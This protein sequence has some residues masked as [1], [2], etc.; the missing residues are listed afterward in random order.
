ME[1]VDPS[2]RVMGTSII[3]SFYTIGLASLGGVAY[4]TREW[5][6]LL[7]VIYAPCIIFVS[8]FWILPESTR[9][10][11]TMGKLKK[12]RRNILQA[13]RWNKTEFSESA[14]RM[15]QHGEEEFMELH[16]KVLVVEEPNSK[17]ET[18][19]GSSYP[20]LQAI[21]NHVILRRV[22]ILSFCWATNTFVYYGL[23]I[24]SVSFGGD[25][26]I[27][28]VSSSLIELPSVL[29]C[30]L[31][32]DTKIFGRKR[33]L[34]GTLFVSGVACICQLALD[35]QDAAMVSP[36]PFSLFLIGKLAITV[37]AMLIISCELHS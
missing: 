5:R 14:Q 19:R 34:M 27:N 4:A 7:W 25:K 9:W 32:V 2:K 18:D 23:S 17:L 28:Y 21:R 3:N 10:L 33:A 1:Y 30:Y 37:S 8:Y 36:G 22:L 15:L 29:I 35:H 24:Y 11:V 6:M 31:L 26:Y 12:A 20:L 16:P 13:G